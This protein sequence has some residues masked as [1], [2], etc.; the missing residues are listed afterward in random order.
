MRFFI[1]SIV[2]QKKCSSNFD[3]VHLVKDFAF[4]FLNCIYR[5][6]FLIPPPLYH[7][8]GQNTKWSRIQR[9][10]IIFKLCCLMNT[11]EAWRKWFS[12]WATAL[13]R[14]FKS[15]HYSIEKFHVPLLFG[16]IEQLAKVELLE[17][18][19]YLSVNIWK[20]FCFRGFS[21]NNRM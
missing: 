4:K 9:Y 10:G 20:L 2:I 15:P 6:R 8:L 19:S 11:E 17:I 14:R 16:K 12:L 18:V 13:A 7:I 3:Y 1:I 5:M 21:D